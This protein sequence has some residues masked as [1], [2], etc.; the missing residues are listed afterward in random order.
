VRRA[1]ER[2]RARFAFVEQAIA[3]A[4]RPLSLAEMER[5]WETAKA[6]ERGDAGP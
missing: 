3:E 5:A 1:T 2:F 4:A 6:A